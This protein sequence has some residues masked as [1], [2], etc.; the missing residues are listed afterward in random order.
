[1]PEVA[2][3]IESSEARGSAG[4]KGRAIACTAACSGS[5]RP[6]FMS[7]RSN[8]IPTV[9]FGESLLC[10]LVSVT[11]PTIFVFLGITIWPCWSRSIEV[12]A[13]ILSFALLFLASRDLDNS[14][15][16]TVPAAS[17]SDAA[18]DAAELAGASGAG[19]AGPAWV[20]RAG[21]SGAGVAGPACVLGAGASG[22]GVVG[23]DCVLWAGAVVW[24]SGEACAVAVPARNNIASIETWAG[25]M[26][27]S[28]LRSTASCL[29]RC[30]R[31][32]PGS[33]PVLP[34]LFAKPG[35]EDLGFLV[36]ANRL[37]RNQHHQ[38][39]KRVTILQSNQDAGK[40]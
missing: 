15:E 25:F 27:R 30:N 11:W 22:A 20:L 39:K 28:I 6:F 10:A 26:V 9:E 3:D 13:S 35:F 23:P 18:A 29:V 2:G 21:A 33:L 14:T 16:T 32:K 17:L 8:A 38:E 4:G 37:H 1:M 7:T 36:S 19:V 40:Q 5:S 31:L 12:L 34:I 24:D